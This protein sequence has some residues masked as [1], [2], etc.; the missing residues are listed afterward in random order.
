MPNT[1]N[2]RHVE[3]QLRAN[4]QGRS[5]LAA[6]GWIERA[7]EQLPPGEKRELG[8]AIESSGQ[9]TTERPELAGH[10][11]GTRD[12]QHRA[13]TFGRDLAIGCPDS[14]QLTASAERP[15]I[16]RRML[17]GIWRALVGVPVSGVSSEQYEEMQRALEAEGGRVQSQV[18][19]GVT[20][21]VANVRQAR[22]GAV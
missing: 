20:E 4:E 7:T 12:P 16:L 15:R 6:I 22:T 13:Q 18:R 17:D 21:L 9:P 10:P 8:Q 14:L 19:K 5:E 11:A 2:A 3:A 1:A